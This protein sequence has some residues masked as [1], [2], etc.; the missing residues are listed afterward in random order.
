LNGANAAE[1][2]P[3]FQDFLIELDRANESEPDWPKLL[4]DLYDAEIALYNGKIT[5]AN[6]LLEARQNLKDAW[7]K[8]QGE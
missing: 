2:G 7:E 6:N 4:N 1:F 5:I 3:K 8:Y